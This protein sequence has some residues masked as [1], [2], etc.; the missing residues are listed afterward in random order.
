VVG[1]KYI[2]YAY[3]TKE[4]ELKAGICSRTRPL[5]EAQSDLDYFH[6]LAASKATSSIYGLAVD[7]FSQQFNAWRLAE[8]L[9]AA[10]LSEVAVLLEGEG[11]QRRAQTGQDGRFRFDD[12]PSGDYRLTASRE[13]YSLSDWFVRPE[14]YKVHSRGCAFVLLPFQID[15]R[16]HGRVFN[17][18]GDPVAN[19]HV[20]L[21]P[22]RMQYGEDF[23]FT[24]AHATSDKNGNYEIKNIRTGEYYVGV[25]LLYDLP[26][27][28]PQPRTFHPGVAG[29]DRAKRIRVGYG[30]ERHEAD[31]ALTEPLRPR[32]FSGVVEWQD[33][34]PAANV[35]VFLEEPPQRF[36]MIR[37]TTDDTGRFGVDGFT[38]TDYYVR[39][40]D[41]SPT[42][43][44]QD[45]HCAEPVYVRAGDEAASN[46]KLVLSIPGDEPASAKERERK[47][48]D[49]WQRGYGW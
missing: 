4:G 26:K 35:D 3:R 16:I 41:H 39:A 31:I 43:F 17:R 45:A 37:A 19:A 15:R 23:P 13:W 9:P 6:G 8:D 2:V 22:T 48:I 10:G 1:R 46:L 30:A 27:D 32:T 28:S 29:I 21:V 12:L 7:A 44:R 20:Q 11:I 47:A 24:V 18:H 14:P 38:G 25:N 49:R 5:E 34:R 36:T 33:G 40:T 42:G